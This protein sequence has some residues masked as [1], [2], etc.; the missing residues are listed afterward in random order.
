MKRNVL[1]HMHV[2]LY[3]AVGRGVRICFRTLVY[4]CVSERSLF[5]LC[6]SEQKMDE[7]GDR[8]PPSFTS[9]NSTDTQETARTH[10]REP[11]PNNQSQLAKT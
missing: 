2:F 1:A 6:V 8:H 5:M 10:T 3:P 4:V 9:S 7:G 11:T